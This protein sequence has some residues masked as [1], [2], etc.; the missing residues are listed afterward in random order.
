[1]RQRLPSSLPWPVPVSASENWL[2][3]KYSASPWKNVCFHHF[4]TSVSS[5]LGP[6]C[7]VQSFVDSLN[8][9]ISLSRRFYVHSVGPFICLFALYYYSIGMICSVPLV[10]VQCNWG[11]WE[12]KINGK[13]IFAFEGGC[14]SRLSMKYQTKFPAALFTASTVNRN[15]R[16]GHW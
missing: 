10:C 1:M 12:T 4:R 5:L 8:I 15:D 16:R 7:C 11:M 9:Y 6:D 2:N 14:H 3:R 13:S